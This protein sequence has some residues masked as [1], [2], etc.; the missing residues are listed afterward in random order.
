MANAAPPFS[1]LTRDKLDI[2]LR[3]SEAALPLWTRFQNALGDEVPD[4]VNEATQAFAAIH[5][6]TK[7]WLETGELDAEE[8]QAH[9]DAVGEGATEAGENSQTEIADQAVPAALAAVLVETLAWAL[10]SLADADIVGEGTPGPGGP[11]MDGMLEAANSEPEIGA[12]R[13]LW[14]QFLAAS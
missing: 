3:L 5:D 12:I 2:L 10:G 7:A 14:R 11:D 6:A 13:D 8:L 9:V 1:N 4:H